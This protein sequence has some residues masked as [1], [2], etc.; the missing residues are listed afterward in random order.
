MMDRSRLKPWQ[1]SRYE[2][3]INALLVLS[4]AVVMAVTEDTAGQSYSGSFSSKVVIGKMITVW[5]ASYGSDTGKDFQFAIGDTAGA[6]DKTWLSYINNLYP[7][8]VVC[9]STRSKTFLFPIAH[10]QLCVNV[11]SKAGAYIKVPV[12]SFAQIGGTGKV[13]LYVEVNAN[14]DATDADAKQAIIFTGNDYFDN[15]SSKTVLRFNDALF[16][17]AG[18]IQHATAM[19]TGNWG[20]TGKDGSTTY[21]NM[22]KS[23]GTSFIHLDHFATIPSSGGYSLA[24]NVTRTAS[25]TDFR[26]DSTEFNGVDAC[27]TEARID[28]TVYMDLACL[29]TAPGAGYTGTVE[30]D[31]K[32]ESS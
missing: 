24:R 7:G 31:F 1:T 15:I 6:N 12:T 17:N 8:E 22:T 28:V 14:G 32:P 25:S 11:N 26:Y 10:Y 9:G 5:G 19:T 20:S 16:S 23:D 21:T 18:A 3:L 30:I 27:P 4:H 13:P 2:V 29:L